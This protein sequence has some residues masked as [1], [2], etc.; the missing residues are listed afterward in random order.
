MVCGW[1]V[2]G[3]WMVCENQNFLILAV[4]AINENQK[5]F[6]FTSFYRSENQKKTQTQ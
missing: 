3:V 6:G 2:D 1:C 4:T 5:K